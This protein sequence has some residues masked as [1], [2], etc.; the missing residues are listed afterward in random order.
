MVPLFIYALIGIN[1]ITFIKI[2]LSALLLLCLID[3]PYGY[4][5]FVRF[6]AMVVF[7]YLAYYSYENGSTLPAFVYGMLALL[8]QPFFKITLGRTLWNVA[9]V[10][11]AIALIGSVLFS[12]KHEQV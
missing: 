9:D 3:M 7:A 2:L 4:Y 1:M 8:F 10:V 12:K 5:Q 6:T 11:I